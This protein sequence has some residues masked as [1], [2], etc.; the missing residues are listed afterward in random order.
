MELITARS[1]LA[2]VFMITAAGG[3][4]GRGAWSPIVMG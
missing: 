2:V 3:V 1:R 4:H